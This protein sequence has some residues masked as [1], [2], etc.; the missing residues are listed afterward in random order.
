MIEKYRKSDLSSIQFLRALTHLLKSIELQ[1]C[2]SAFPGEDQ[3]Y[4]LRHVSADIRPRSLATP[5]SLLL[6][7]QLKKAPRNSNPS[8]QERNNLSR[9]D[10]HDPTTHS[11]TP[12]AP[13]TGTSNPIA[14]STA[15][16]PSAPATRSQSAT[17]SRHARNGGRTSTIRACTRKRWSGTSRSAW[18]RAYFG[19]STRSAGWMSIC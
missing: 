7:H 5:A 15:P 4:S 9:L 2:L 10:H 18:R 17:R 1:R 14:A 13:A 16:S 12:T 6:K 3:Y 11:P 8:T 19:R